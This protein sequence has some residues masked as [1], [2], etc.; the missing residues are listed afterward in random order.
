MKL[1]CHYDARDMDLSV[2]KVSDLNFRNYSGFTPE[3]LTDFV[4]DKSTLISDEFLCGERARGTFELLHDKLVSSFEGINDEKFSN[5]IV[6]NN[7][8][9]DITSVEPE[10]LLSSMLRDIIY[11]KPICGLCQ[12]INK[13]YEPKKVIKDTKL[14]RVFK[15]KKLL[16]YDLSYTLED[17][18]REQPCKLPPGYHSFQGKR[19]KVKGCVLPY[20]AE[21]P[22]LL[23]PEKYFMDTD[24]LEETRKILG[25]KPETRSIQLVKAAIICAED[26]EP[27][28]SDSEVENYEIPTD[29]EGS[30]YGSDISFSSDESSEEEENDYFDLDYHAQKERDLIHPRTEMAEGV[31]QMLAALDTENCG[32]LSGY[33]TGC[34]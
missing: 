14:K 15:D 28:E 32:A 18:T 7:Y 1:Q 20:N 17:K 12:T 24:L 10:D 25:I 30:S 11:V 13:T 29:S 4:E 34:Q 21:I 8:T 2:L 9:S 22:I 26:P 6:N 16:R 3:E 23:C 19:N 27:E 5:D 33:I 31:E